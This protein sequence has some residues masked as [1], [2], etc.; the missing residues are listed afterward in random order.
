MLLYLKRTFFNFG[1]LEIYKS[2]AYLKSVFG[3]FRYVESELVLIISA[4][5]IVFITSFLKEN[6][7]DLYTAIQKKNI[8]F[9]WSAYYVPLILVI[10]SMS[11]SPSNPVFMYAQY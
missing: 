9:R 7:V 11:F 2:Q 10:L 1:T 8:A 4:S 5:I 6:K 3:S